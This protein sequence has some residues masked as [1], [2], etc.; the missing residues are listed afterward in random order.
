MPLPT[1]D[2]I[3]MVPVGA[4]QV[5]CVVTLAAGVAGAEGAA[6]TTSPVIAVEVPQ[7]LVAVSE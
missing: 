1:G 4:A 6:F 7:L 5:G 2:V 3:V